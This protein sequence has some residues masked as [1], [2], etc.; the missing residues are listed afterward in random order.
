MMRAK[1]ETKPTKV[2]LKRDVGL[3]T[4]VALGV[5]SIIGSGMFTMPAVMGSVAGPA[6]ILAVILTGGELQLC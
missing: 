1:Q 2:G 5:G 3:F 4:L 6:L